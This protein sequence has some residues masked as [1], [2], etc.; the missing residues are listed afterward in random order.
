MSVCPALFVSAPASNQGKT[1]ITAGIARYHRNRGVRV[2]VFK[3]GPDFLDPQ[4]L[5]RASGHPVH[6]LDLWMTG[7]DDCRQRLRK[8]AAEADLIV[9]EGVMGLFDGTP[10]SADLAEAL[11]VPVVAVID[12]SSMAQTFAAIAHGLATFRPAL[13]FLGVLANR[14][15]S[16]RHAQMLTRSLPTDLSYLGHVARDMEVVLPARHLGLVQAREVKDLEAKLEAAAKVIAVTSLVDLPPPVA[17]TAL[18][19]PEIPRLLSGM[20]IAVARDAAFNFL[21]PANLDLLRAMGAE[22]VSFSPLNDR[23][24]PNADAVWLPGGYP[25]LHL[26]QLSANEAMLKALRDHCEW[27]KRIY[28]ECG[29]MLYLLDTLADVHGN[30]ARLA[31]VLPGNARMQAKLA[32]LGMQSVE[33]PGVGRLRGHTFHYSRMATSLAP[34]AVARHATSGAAGEPLYQHGSIIASYLH[35]WFP[36][37]PNAVAKLF[38]P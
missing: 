18:P 6:N 20:R 17:F 25:E 4:I 27:G 16:D 38:L 32:G 28:A 3:T 36:S 12:A 24:L 30:S 14:V 31:A 23:E 22:L 21:Y 2:R 9:I 15:A 1:T 13:P 37:N 26:G 29:G 5:E 8:A 19:A 7:E 33:L 34:I 11:G 35:A 10:S